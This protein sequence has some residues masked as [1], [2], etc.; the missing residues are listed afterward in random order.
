MV[1]ESLPELK[2]L[3]GLSAGQVY[4]AMLFGPPAI[5]FRRTVQRDAAAVVKRVVL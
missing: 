3:V 2:T 5:R 4:A 1:C